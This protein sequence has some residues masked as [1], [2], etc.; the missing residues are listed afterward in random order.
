MCCAPHVLMQ[1]SDIM[2]LHDTGTWILV[3]WLAWQYR[4]LS[5]EHC[6]A[7]QDSNAGECY[8]HINACV[9]D[10]VSEY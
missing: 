3:P 4:Q 2:M 10:D 1:M 9:I 8:V 6:D 7:L 5:L